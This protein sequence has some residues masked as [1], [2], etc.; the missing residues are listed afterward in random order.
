MSHSPYIVGFGIACIDYIVVAPTI[1][2]GEHTHV[3]DFI[4]QGGGL[5][6]TALVAAARLGARTKILG[7]VGDDEIGVRIVDGLEA[8]GVDASDL[9]KVPGGESLLSVVLV[10][11][12]TAERTIYCKP[13][14][15]I[16]CSTNLINLD[17]I[18]EAD[19]V[20]LDAHWADG[21]RVVAR[22]AKE[23][24]VPIVCDISPNSQTLDIVAMCDYPIVA[25]KAALA[26][27]GTDD[28][29]LA[30]NRLLSLGVKAAVITC[31]S[32]G[33]YY[34]SDS[35]WGHVPAFEVEAVDTT[36]AGDVFHGAFAFGIA[37][38]WN[39]EETVRFASAV[40]AI[41]CTELGGRAGIPMLEEVQA[42]IAARS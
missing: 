39:I 17:P 22:K 28:Y 12:Q 25:R 18:E 31:G 41:K 35:T 33:A 21:A 24:G 19:V 15:N 29:H 2:P 1:E 34:A 26:F 16:E 36:G 8:E 5:T 38:G 14:R 4:V 10:D 27:A 20:L 40:A 13:D 42:F 11:P 6:G 37:N 30:L 9:I 23:A 7:R 32:E 3:R